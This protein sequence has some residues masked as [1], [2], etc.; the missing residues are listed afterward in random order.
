M[1]SVYVWAWLY[2][3]LWA[4]YKSGLVMCLCCRPAMSILQ[5]PRLSTPMRPVSPVEL[6]VDVEIVCWKFR[7]A[8]PHCHLFLMSS[9][10]IRCFLTFDIV[11]GGQEGGER[12]EG[13][14]HASWLPEVNGSCATASSMCAR[15]RLP[16][17]CFRCL[18]QISM[19]QVSVYV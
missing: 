8:K 12:W 14:C 18:Q 11:W 17:I 9:Q 15:A 2:L 4:S 3:G 19:F 5:L 10:I 6:R 7:L 13:W 16:E 1:W